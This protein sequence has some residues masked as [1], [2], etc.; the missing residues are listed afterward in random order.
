MLA[1]W[2]V[3][4]CGSL[5]GEVGGM[6]G[7]PAWVDRARTELLDNGKIAAIK[8]VRSHTGLDL[9]ESKNLVETG[10]LDDPERIARLPVV[11]PRK[12]T[13]CFPASALVCTPDGPRRIDE[14]RPGDAV[15]SL[16]VAGG[17]VVETVTR[18]KVHPPAR[19]WRVEC[20]KAAP[21][22]VTANHRMR[23]DRGWL[24]VDQLV[25]GDR[26]IHASCASAYVQEVGLSARV[27][28]VF[29]LYTTGTHAFLIGGFVAHNF[30]FIP[31]LR[32]LLHRVF[33]DP[34]YPPS[35]LAGQRRLLLGA[36]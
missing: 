23:S 26:L 2:R 4:L 8:L 33:I 7:E 3:G 9:K 14:I 10:G 20:S 18:S 25:Q 21:L 30:S 17:L 35:R 36:P 28:P 13:G 19:L 31:E 15:W 12:N 1:A 34:F 11:V 6:D 32:T 16:S 27:E 24:R 5:T 29:N 22:L